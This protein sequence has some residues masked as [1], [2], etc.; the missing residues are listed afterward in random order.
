MPLKPPMID[1][2]DE[3]EWG[4]RIL[5]NN[6]VKIKGTTKHGGSGVKELKESGS[7]EK[8]V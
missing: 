6:C 1:G 5:R 7:G 3:K 8:K 2:W 4:F